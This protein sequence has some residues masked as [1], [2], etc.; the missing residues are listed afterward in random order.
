MLKAFDLDPTFFMDSLI[1]EMTPEARFLLLGLWGL[2]DKNNVLE[3]NPG[4][5][6]PQICPCTPYLHYDS[7]LEELAARGIVRL[8]DGPYRKKAS[9]PLIQVMLRSGK[10]NTARLH[11][12]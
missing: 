8:F 12:C 4:E 7:C 11:T 5:I 3:N 1:G 10:I 2:A 6:L 9:T